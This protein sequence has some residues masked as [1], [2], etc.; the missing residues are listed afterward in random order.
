MLTVSLKPLF[1]RNQE[2]IGMYYQHQP[3]LNTIIKKLPGVRWSQTNKCWYIPL[4]SD[5]YNSAYK[6][7]EGKADL[8]ITTLKQY[9]DKRKKV[10]TT[11][12][13]TSTKQNIVK[14]IPSTSPVWKLSGENLEALEKF[15]QL[16]KLKAYS[17][18]T[19]R[20]YRNEFIQLLQLLK[21]KPVNELTPEELKR[22]L[23]Y[24]Y[25]KLHLTENT[26]HSRI[27]AMKFYY[28]QVL[29]RENFF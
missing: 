15:V 3:S 8:D 29:K 7:L 4:S 17:E 6:A 5:S 22:Y 20:T 16:L 19:I 28:E 18:S 23:V 2:C 25:E 14:S 12:I 27:N 24:C 26:L 10:V 9:L 21:K 1:H 13:P 11:T